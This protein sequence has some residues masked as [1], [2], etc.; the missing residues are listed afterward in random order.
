MSWSGELPDIS[1]LCIEADKDN[2]SDCDCD[3]YCKY[4]DEFDEY[5]GYEIK[6][7]DRWFYG[8]VLADHIVEPPCYADI[9]DTHDVEIWEV[10]GDSDYEGD[11][12]A[13]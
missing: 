8:K 11:S 10:S 9:C 4:Y 6:P 13:Y 12:D 2:M 5:A 1:S 3:D 7:F